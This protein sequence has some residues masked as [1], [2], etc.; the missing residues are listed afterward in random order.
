[1]TIKKKQKEALLEWIAEG[2]DSNEINKRAAKFKPKFIVSRRAI[3]HYRKTREIS[4]AKIKEAGELSALTSGLALAD[5]RVA[6]L[7]KL[8]DHMIEDLLPPAKVGSRLWLDQAKTVAYE[9]YEYQE[10]NKGE[11]DTLRGVLDDIA[12]EVGGRV[13]KSDLTSDG[14]S[15]IPEF[16]PEQ[17]LQRVTML[18]NIA[19]KRKNES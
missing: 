19:E 8:A 2:L 3:T 1:M 15:L 18:M 11:V 12:A 10:F 17:I 13:K 14:K 7:Q 16:T 6:V 5:E 9:M 4:I